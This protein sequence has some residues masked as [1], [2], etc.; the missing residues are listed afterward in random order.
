MQPKFTIRKFAQGA[1][2]ALLCF[3]I[4]TNTALPVLANTDNLTVVTQGVEKTIATHTELIQALKTAADGDIIVLP[5]NYSGTITEADWGTSS[6]DIRN[7]VTIKGDGTLT[8]RGLSLNTYSN[9][10]L[11]DISLNI[12][13]EGIQG[14]ALNVSTG[15]LLLD[16]VKTK[17]SDQ[18]SETRPMVT[19]SAGELVVTGDQEESKFDTL[20]ILPNATATIQNS[21]FTTKQ[22][23]VLSENSTLETNSEFLS[24]F[25]GQGTLIFSGTQ[26]LD[27]VELTDVRNIILT[28]NA[29]V[30]LANS[31]GKPNL[32]IQ[33]GSTIKTV[34]ELEFGHIIGEGKFETSRDGG[35]RAIS[36][37]NTIDYLITSPDKN[38]TDKNQYVYLV[39]DEPNTVNPRFQHEPT[40]M[41]LKKELNT[42]ILLKD[43]T[44][45]KE[46]LLDIIEH[47]M[48]Y[49]L[50][51]NKSVHPKYDSASKEIKDQ[52]DNAIKQA[53]N[54]YN[55]KAASED[56]VTSAEDALYAALEALINYK[57]TEAPK[58]HVPV[59]TTEVV[60]SEKVGTVKVRYINEANGSKLIEDEVIL[61]DAVVATIT[62]TI[63]KKDGVIVSE[64][65][66]ETKTGATYDTRSIRKP[67]ITVGNK[68]YYLNEDGLFPMED[69][70]VR[71]GE[72]VVTY[73][74]EE[75]E[76]KTGSSVTEQPKPNATVPTVPSPAKP[77]EPTTP[78][79]PQ[80]GNK[81]SG[82]E[83]VDD[84]NPSTQGSTTTQPTKPITSVPNNFPTVEPLPEAPLTDL[85]SWDIPNDFPMVELPFANVDDL[86]GH[87]PIDES[88]DTT[89]SVIGQTGGLIDGNG[90]S[91]KKTTTEQKPSA[92]DKAINTII[93][94]SLLPDTG[95]KENF[96]AIISGTVL[97]LV[98]LIAYTIR[99]ASKKQSM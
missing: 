41:Y 76:T 29:T 85:W 75:Q 47:E 1:A 2:S 18:Q 73:R 51:E 26:T 80:D 44:I 70:L 43:N 15:Q 98:M 60:K 31:T 4:V 16:N 6:L 68:T 5:A 7:N 9:V 66:V 52:Y 67:K 34:K 91:N 88:T 24:N 74:Y 30:G 38:F 57:P 42:H 21:K 33:S 63:V 83:D 71:E 13:G 45:D 23:V 59:E 65:P 55:D 10:T 20:S 58:P 19:V 36:M 25:T 77:T 82:R 32:D 37:V 94:P 39:T 81:P 50:V 95:V 61:K 40:G 48:D 90:T 89:A 46:F 54:V 99:R 17:V 79:K 27:Q 84:E 56:D 35:I 96:I 69:G 97:G 53:F 87:D 11:K 28:N 22:P 3:T 49:D 93:K 78:S 72:T 14:G 64:K 8:L 12:L 62:T 92:I 86:I